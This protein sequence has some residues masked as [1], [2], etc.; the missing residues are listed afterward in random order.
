MLLGCSTIITNQACRL[1]RDTVWS[2]QK[3]RFTPSLI[4]GMP[5]VH[6]E[7]MT[8]DKHRMSFFSSNVNEGNSLSQVPVV[9][10]T[11]CSTIRHISSQH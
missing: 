11:V 6:V 9:V 3:A 5:H 1:G 7:K 8:R 4:A 2:G 10:P